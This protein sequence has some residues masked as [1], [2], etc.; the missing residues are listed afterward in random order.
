M[1]TCEP[2]LA[3]LPAAGDWLIT[4]PLGTLTLERSEGSGSR[5]AER[6][7]ARRSLF[8]L[9][10]HLRHSHR[11]AGAGQQERRH[12][13]AGDEQQGERPQRRA[14]ST[15]AARLRHRRVAPRAHHW[16]RRGRREQ[17]ARARVGARRCGVPGVGVGRRGGG[18][19][20]RQRLALVLERCDQLVGVGVALGGI[21]GE[22]AQ[23]DRV[24]R[25]GDAL[26]ERAWRLRLR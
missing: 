13:D 21:L 18:R 11:L 8:G 22:R 1:F 12:D 24:E 17:P 10:G 15:S 3:S 5:P 9:S 2:F 14:A 7:V 20:R 4:M 6:G 23:D 25:G 16:R 26:P 19:Q